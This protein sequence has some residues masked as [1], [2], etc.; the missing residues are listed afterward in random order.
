MRGM[1]TRNG[2]R[3]RPRVYRVKDALLAVADGKV[4]AMRRGAYRFQGRTTMRGRAAVRLVDA[5]GRVY[6]VLS[7][8]WFDWIDLGGAEIV[9]NGGAR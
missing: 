6:R 3:T 1:A 4:V 9:R 8:F 2:A 7:R 5:S